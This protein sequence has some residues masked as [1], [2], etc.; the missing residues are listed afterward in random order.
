MRPGLEPVQ[1]CFHV[2][3][4]QPAT[5]LEVFGMRA[6][7]ERPTWSTTVWT[8]HCSGL[9]CGCRPGCPLAG[10]WRSQSRGSTGSRSKGG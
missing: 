1:T 9:G 8:V 3:E 10:I 4:T 6:V 5:F 2:A 7:T